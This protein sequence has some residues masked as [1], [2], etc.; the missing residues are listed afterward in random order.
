MVVALVNERIR[1]VLQVAQSDHAVK[2]TKDVETVT[3]R[4][5]V[6]AIRGQRNAPSLS[7]LLSSTELYLSHDHA[8]KERIPHVRN[9][10]LQAR[11][12]RLQARMKDAEYARIIRDVARADASNVEIEAAR[13]SKFAPQMSL[14]VNVIVTMATCFTAGYFLFKHSTGTQTG[15]LIG[16][17]VAMIIAMAVEVLLVLTRMYTIDT[18]VDQHVK[19]RQR[20]ADR[21]KPSSENVKTSS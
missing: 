20:M 11:V 17:V 3:H 18:A 4:A 2:R 16:G 10:Q 14:G 6:N 9:P 1:K 5:L 15:G 21:A 13:M 12:E 7:S 8:C 19:K